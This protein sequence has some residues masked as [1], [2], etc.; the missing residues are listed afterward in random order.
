MLI[1]FLI[2]P[3]FL[4]GQELQQL[5]CVFLLPIKTRIIVIDWLKLH[6]WPCKW[7]CLIPIPSWPLSFN[8]PLLILACFLSC[9][10]PLL[11][12]FFFFYHQPTVYVWREQ[13]VPIILNLI[14]H[15]VGTCCS[16][17]IFSEEALE[18]GDS[19]QWGEA[20]IEKQPLPGSCQP[21]EFQGESREGRWEHSEPPAYADPLSFATFCR[22]VSG[23]EGILLVMNSKVL[24][25]VGLVC[26]NC[27]AE[28]GERETCSYCLHYYHW[29]KC[30]HCRVKIA[31]ITAWVNIFTFAITFQGR[32]NVDYFVKCVQI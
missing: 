25:T 16:Q 1:L 29:D 22:R 20:E 21:Q 30:F 6:V 9:S 11:L 15:T 2:F 10:P 7:A 24:S 8:P 32:S 28:K 12:F 18:K 4:D 27:R 19:Q 17:G 23:K 31:T 5:S 3:A 26:H 14:E 13:A